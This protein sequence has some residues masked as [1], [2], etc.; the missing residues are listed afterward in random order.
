MVITVE[1]VKEL[2]ERTGAGM[3]ECKR[4]LEAAQGDI[5]AAIEAM[6]KAGMAK[7]A[8]KAD[9][10]AAEGMIVVHVG[11]DRKQGVLLEVNCETDFVARDAH[12][13]GFVRNVATLALTHHCQEVAALLALPYPQSRHTV[14]QE[15]HEL[16]GKLGENIQ[17]RRIA[18]LQAKG[19]VGAYQHSHRIGALV[20]LDQDDEALGKEIAMHIVAS[21]PQAIKPT[22]VPSTLIEKEKA[23][24]REQAQ[25]SGK[26]AAIVEKMIEGRIKKFLNE[27]S[28]TEQPFVKNP[29]ET[30]GQLLKNKQ[31]N[32]LGFVRFQLGEG[33]EKPVT[34]FAT[35]VMAQ[36]NK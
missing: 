34:D 26:P 31:V 10:T 2:R 9:R 12:F 20:Q 5:E 15:R 23:I 35:D 18:N 7:A 17:V 36:V 21:N 6:R 19:C 27:I 32:I 30:V 3:M 16:V 11:S 13:A 25:S 33:I 8:K 24:Y 22:D 1:Q 4:A 14:E 28:L 29:E